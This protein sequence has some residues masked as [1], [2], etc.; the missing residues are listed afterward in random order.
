M[1]GLDYFKKKVSKEKDRSNLEKMNT[2]DKN[3]RNELNICVNKS[4]ESI[5]K[6][7]LLLYGFYNCILEESINDF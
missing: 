5:K 7:I 3:Q 4:Y 6:S 1:N 2:S